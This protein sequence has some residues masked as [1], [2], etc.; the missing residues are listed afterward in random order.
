[1]KRFLDIR[2]S[3]AMVVAC[4]ALFVAL[5][6]VGYTA[7]VLPANSVGTKHLKKNAV[8]S[9]KVKGL[10]RSDFK[11]G[12]LQP[13]LWAYV[14]STGTLRGGRG[15]VASSRLSDGNFSVTFNRSIVNCAAT[16]NYLRESTD[17]SLNV[18]LH[19]AITRLTATELR[20]YI[21]NSTSS[22]NVNIPFGLIVV[23]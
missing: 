12:Q 20:I 19:L 2:P 23:C 18:S 8:T 7:I 14:S 6:G 10:L 9:P 1:M 16:A 4:A 5:T 22:T 17:V 21:W 11:P 3:P 13:R 15:V